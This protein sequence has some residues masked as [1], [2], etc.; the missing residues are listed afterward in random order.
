MNK[1]YTEVSLL[2]VEDDDIDAMAVERAMKKHKIANPMVRVKNGQK[3]LDLLRQTD[4]IQKPYTVLLDLNMPIM[5]GIEFLKELRS[6]PKLTDTVV[7]V[8]TTSEADED[9]VAA[10][11]QNIAGYIMKFDSDKGMLD[12]VDMLDHYWRVVVLPE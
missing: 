5:G 10:Y 11:K 12:I 7:F 9:K 2:L 6:D 8:L 1:K 4:T 3:A